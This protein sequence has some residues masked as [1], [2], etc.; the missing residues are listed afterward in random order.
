M[1]AVAG[2]PDLQSGGDVIATL[3][4][5]DENTSRSRACIQDTPVECGEGSV[6]MCAQVVPQ[7]LSECQLDFPAVKFT[8]DDSRFCAHMT[9][10]PC[11]PRKKQKSHP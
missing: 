7:S 9:I 5:V 2:A 11:T 6:P 10:N 4:A 1:S 8:D 3:T